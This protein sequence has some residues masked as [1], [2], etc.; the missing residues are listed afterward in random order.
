MFQDVTLNA[1]RDENGNGM[2]DM[3]T[4]TAVPNG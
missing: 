2:R 3:E 1:G 4:L